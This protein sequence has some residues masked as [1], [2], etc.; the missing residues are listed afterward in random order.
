MIENQTFASAGRLAAL[1]AIVGHG[2]FTRSRALE[3]TGATGLTKDPPRP[4]LLRDSETEERWMR[5]G[6]VAVFVRYC[7]GAPADGAA[8]ARREA[9]GG[10]RRQGALRGPQPCHGALRR[11]EALPAPR[12]VGDPPDTVDIDKEAS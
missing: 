3:L 9:V 2:A 7:T 8:H 11:G 5:V 12:P 4:A 1:E 6:D 10:R